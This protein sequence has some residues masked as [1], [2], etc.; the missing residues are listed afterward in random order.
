MNIVV[1]D[2]LTSFSDYVQWDVLAEFGD[3]TVYD[4]TPP[5]KVI[6]RMVDAD[7]VLVN[8]TV[9]S[10]EILQQLP[11]LKYIGL[12][13][14]GTNLVD[15]AAARERGI[16]VTSVPD[17][18]TQSVAQMAIAHLLN[19]TQRVGSL[20]GRVRGGGWT[21][22]VEE[23]FNGKPLVELTGLGMGILGFGRIGRATAEMARAF[24][25]RILAADPHPPETSTAVRFVELD[26]LFRV[27]RSNMTPVSLDDLPGDG[28]TQAC[29]RLLDILPP[30]EGSKES[31]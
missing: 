29:S 12:L 18:A 8:G 31:V 15:V 13:I 11:R 14:T 28:Q 25:M 7:A 20:A 4:R 30:V 2:G 19:L 22:S 16:G 27:H 3:L 6:E 10:R 5:E 17:Y 23:A 9:L 26:T 24:G 21:E 1:L